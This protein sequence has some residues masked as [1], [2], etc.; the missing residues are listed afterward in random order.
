MFENLFSYV[1]Y[2]KE[3][4]EGENKEQEVVDELDASLLQKLPSV[5]P[6]SE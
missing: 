5:T 2:R 4:F 1:C 6:T 3:D